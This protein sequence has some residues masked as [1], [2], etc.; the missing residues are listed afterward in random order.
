M[1]M[2]ITYVGMDAHKETINLALLAPGSTKPLEWK[3]TTEPQAVRRLVR[4]IKKSAPSEVVACYE[5]GP[6]GFALQ[7]Q[8]EGLGVRCIVIAP[9][10]IP[11][12]AGDRVKTDKRDAR[13][14]AELL[15]AGLLTEVRSP[16][17]E[18]EA[19]RDLCRAREDAK[20]DRLRARHRLVKML[21]RR[22]LVYRDGKAW[23]KAFRAWLS[24]L[25]FEHVA[26]QATFEDYLRAVDGVDE[27]LRDLEAK[28]AEISSTTEYQTVVGLLRCFRG[29]D[30]LTAMVLLTELGDLTR[31]D[32]P[33]K[34]MA[35]LGLTPSEYSSG[36]T[37]R[38]GGISKAGNAHAR[39]VLIESAWHYRHGTH[40]GV[41][42]RRRREGQPGWAIA[43]ADK[44]QSRLNRRYRRLT[45]NGK[46][47][48]KA[49]VAVARE[50][51]G[52]LWAT[53]T[54][55]AAKQEAMA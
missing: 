15:R 50:L 1:T 21:T 16:T 5:A 30:T 28:I 31:F 14:L 36:G 19:V 8:L 29:I 39:R 48:T 53:L 37:S 47:S 43:I 9:A 38:R 42:L 22:G 26:S 3:T 33:R 34:L 55:H 17:P 27:R 25:H 7:R 41:R 4:K 46:P 45:A 11:K 23:T 40:V 20:E 35:Y 12:R 10:L 51:S 49:V 54:T 18:Q 44:A 2:G 24:K 32:S 52:F 6:C 13:K